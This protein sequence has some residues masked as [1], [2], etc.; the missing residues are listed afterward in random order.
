MIFQYSPFII[1]LLL[2]AAITG[3][4]ALISLRRR[5][6][7]VIPPFIL[8]MAAITIWTGCYAVQLASADLPT[9]LLITAILYPAIV[10]TPVAWLLIVLCYTGYDHLLSR[11]N[12]ALL[13]VVPAIVLALLYTN[14][15]HKLYYTGYTPGTLAGAV[16]WDFTHGPFFWLQVAYA[17]LCIA[18]A[19]VLI[20]QRFFTSPAIYRRQMVLMVLATGIPLSANILYVLDLNPFPGL[21]I[22]PFMFAATGIL[23]VVGIL[24]FHLFTLAPVAYPLIFTAIE[25]AV[26]VLDR[27]DLVSDLNPA[28]RKILRSGSRYPVGEPA[29]EV[30]PPDI[31]E[32]PA[33]DGTGDGAVRHAVIAGN[34]GIL[35]D[36]EITCRPILTGVGGY[37][38]RLFMLR[39]VTER[40]K[41][42][43]AIERA[44][45]KL[46]LLSSITRH[47]ML[48][49]LTALGGFL[50][51]A[52]VEKDPE[53]QRKYLVAMEKIT[54]M[55][56][57][58]LE[59]TR[60]YQDLGI[61][62]PVWQDVEKLVRA[63]AELLPAQGVRVE[64]EIRPAGLEI[65][66]DLLLEKVFY[67]LIDNALRYGGEAMTEIRVSSRKENRELVIVFADNGMGI[68]AA[69][70]SRIF[71]KG[72]GKNTGLGLF[73]SQEI[74]SITGITITEN[75]EPGKG[76]RFVITVPEGM[77]R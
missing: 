46:N 13:F 38:G 62:E 4:L 57:T 10:T 48:N 17:Y 8:M 24:R 40:K 14:P 75:G 39:D 34:D 60:D 59:F 66:A 41:T 70:K 15:F 2:S 28:A 1:P 9:N 56:Q 54:R 55:F 63:K 51:M 73:L 16:V 6:D 67:N 72:F 3:I 20:L 29:G 23:M 35:R 64:S 18:V 49:K 58:E 44:N 5:D 68:P 22:T 47:D 11:R 42:R 12:T 7:P 26:I 31:A 77:Y 36:Y 74:L 37:G 76:A 65:F 71:T 50:D 45:R 30:L 27:N 32:F 69:E 21:D 52:L 43:T 19:F 25:D 53:I 33:C 61:H